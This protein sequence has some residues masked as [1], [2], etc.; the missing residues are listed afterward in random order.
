MLPP[1]TFQKCVFLVLPRHWPSGEPGVFLGPTAKWLFLVR[2]H[3][4][5]GLPF[6][7][8]V[9]FSPC[10]CPSNPVLWTGTRCRCH[11]GF[12]GKW[13]HLPTRNTC[14]AFLDIVFSSCLPFFPRCLL[15][16]LGLLS[17]PGVTHEGCRDGR[18]LSEGGGARP[19]LQ[20]PGNEP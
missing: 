20:F 7:K 11:L 2:L 5:H 4:S 17:L 18:G 12:G 10:S 6:L 13:V 9:V 3:A 16:S 19:P 1:V 8:R 14:S 15:L